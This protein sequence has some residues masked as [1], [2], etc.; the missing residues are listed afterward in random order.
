MA[1]TLILHTRSYRPTCMSTDALSG[2][3]LGTKLGVHLPNGIVERLVL[4]SVL[5]AE[6][7]SGLGAVDHVAVLADGL[8]ELGVGVGAETGVRERALGGH[9]NVVAVERVS[10]EDDALACGLWSLEGRHESCSD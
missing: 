3:S 8:A 9:G 10:R 1:H 4:G 7:L 5:E 2:D 6:D